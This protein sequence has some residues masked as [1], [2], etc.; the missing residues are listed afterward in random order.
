MGVVD[1]QRETPFAARLPLPDERLVYWTV[2][3]ADFRRVPIVDDYLF[4]LARSGRAENTGKAYAR[5]VTIFLRWCDSRRRSWLDPSALDD[6]QAF[7]LID[8]ARHGRGPRSETTAN[9]LL[10]AV[11][12]LLRFAVEAGHLPRAVLGRLYSVKD[13]RFLPVEARGD[14]PITDERLSPRHHLP[15]PLQSEPPK[16]IS[17]TR[18]VGM[19]R[20]ARSNRDRLLLSV[21]HD[22]GLRVGEALGLRRDDVHFLED[23]QALGC[24]FEGP[25][26]HVRRRRN[27]NGAVA[28]SRQSRTVPAPPEVVE[29]YGLYL[30]ERDRVPAAR[31]SAYL[32][33][34]LDPPEGEPMR[35]RNVWEL[36]GRLGRAAG[37]PMTVS[38]HTLRHCYGTS[39]ADAERPIDV[40][41]ALMGHSSLRSTMVYLHPSR[42]RRRAA[43]AHMAGVRNLARGTR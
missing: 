13:Y 26:L 36:V 11:R 2:L 27:T 28:K 43:V 21:M 3:D 5:D 31:R 6:F 32:F 30:L 15:A 29:W 7:L 41:A 25:H 33:V 37:I 38:P 40:I 34:N 18:F 10:T 9:R 1:L 20:A 14:R 17:E 23:S 4:S 8:P 42:E 35:Y 24:E 19:L 16:V 22:C 12:G 39:L